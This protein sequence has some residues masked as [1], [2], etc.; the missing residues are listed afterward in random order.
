MFT[1]LIKSHAKVNLIL[2]LG[3][4]N[5]SGRYDIHFVMQ[6]ISLSDEVVVDIIDGRDIVIEC[7]DPRVPIDE[8]NLCYKAVQIMRKVSGRSDGVKIEIKKRI[9]SAGGLGGGSGNAAAVVSALNR[10]W[11]LGMTDDD[12][13]RAVNPELGTDA[14]FF[15]RGGTA[16]VRA[17]GLEVE[18]IETDLSIPF[19]FVLPDIEIPVKKTAEVYKYFQPDRVTKRPDMDGMKSVL[20]GRYLNGVAS[21][22]FNAFEYSLPPGYGD[23]P[24]I[25]REMIGAGCLNAA[26][27]GAGPA[28]FGICE[29]VADTERIAEELK[30]RY[31]RVFIASTAGTVKS[32]HEK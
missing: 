16:E 25:K 15:I 7:D 9:P 22:I 14:S 10:V 4:K 19:V 24:N 2:D 1:M 29:S 31:K 17:N 30:R 20:E 13:I 11:R 5:A 23:I 28:L 18:R 26:M 3:E 32:S 6:E 12:L 8:E 27:C 21:G